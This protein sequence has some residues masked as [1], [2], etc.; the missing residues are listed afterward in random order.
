MMKK[1]LAAMALAGMAMSAQAALVIN[2]GFDN[3]PG[4]ASQGWVFTNA[5]TPGGLTTGWFQGT[6]SVFDAQSGASTSYALANYNNAPA[7]GTINSWLTTP[8]FD[9]T[10]GA[11]IFFYLRAA[12]EGYT[13]QV[14]FGFTTGSL[15]MTTITPVPDSGWTLYNIYLPAN[16]LGVTSFA[17]QYTGAA[18]AS[19]AVGLDSL[20]VDVPEPASMALFAAGLMGLGAI[21]RRSRA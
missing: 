8:E 14:T 5:S 11:N 16:T 10:T 18:D 1:A 21:R 19:N 13:D 7:G 9:A 2:E 3:V 20:T 4:L 15:G 17:F 12:G 6:S